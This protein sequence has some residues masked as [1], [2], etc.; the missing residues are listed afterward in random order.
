MN[1]WGWFLL[2]NVFLLPSE[3]S[4][5]EAGKNSPDHF[6]FNINIWVL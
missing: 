2:E 5:A 6:C 4:G 1:F 3:S